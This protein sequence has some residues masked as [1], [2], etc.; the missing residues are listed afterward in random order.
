ML[1]KEDTKRLEIEDFGLPMRIGFLMLPQDYVED[2]D[3]YHCALRY[4]GGT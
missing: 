1:L 4:F 3:E 2:G